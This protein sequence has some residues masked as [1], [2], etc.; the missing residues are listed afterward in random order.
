MSDEPKVCRECGWK[1]AATE[2]D[3]SGY[4]GRNPSDCAINKARW[5]LAQNRKTMMEEN[6][7]EQCESY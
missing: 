6:R 1:P 5:V 2:G 7:D 3:P 4:C